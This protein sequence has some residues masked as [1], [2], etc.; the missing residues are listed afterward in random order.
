MDA[1]EIIEHIQ[2][3]VHK[4]ATSPENKFG[5]GVYYHIESVVKNAKLLAEKYQ[6]DKEVVVIAAWLHDI[7]SITD[8]KLYKEHHIYGA[9]IAEEI[10]KELN[11]E[12]EKINLVK[13]CIKNHRGSINNE[14]LT[15]EEKC[16]ADADAVSHL[17]NIPGLLYL[18]YVERKMDINEGKEFVKSK[19][20]RSFQKLSEESK[21]IYLEKYNNAMELL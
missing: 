20:K 13:E 12:E 14:R 17:D 21:E 19:L 10:L 5:I 1:K 2:N 6:A 18:A 7:A 8:Y 16:V 15:V 4:R 3:E 9:K 11:Y